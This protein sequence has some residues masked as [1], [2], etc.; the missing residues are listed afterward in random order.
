MH[1]PNLKKCLSYKYASTAQLHTIEVVKAGWSVENLIY[2]NNSGYGIETYD[3]TS[4]PY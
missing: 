2:S 1:T 4:E 3:P